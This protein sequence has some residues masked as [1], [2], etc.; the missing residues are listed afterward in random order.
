M[1]E[2]NIVP[3]ALIDDVPKKNPLAGRSYIK[4]PK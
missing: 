4:L 3:F 1:I 2:Q